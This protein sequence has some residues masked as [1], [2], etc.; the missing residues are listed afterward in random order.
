MK[1]TTG[2]NIFY[3]ASDLGVT[4]SHLFEMCEYQMTPHDRV[5]V[6]KNGNVRLYSEGKLIKRISK[7]QVKKWAWSKGIAQMPNGTWEYV[8][9]ND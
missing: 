9:F 3:F 4:T 1:T 6:F 8:I 7:A 2:T 5:R